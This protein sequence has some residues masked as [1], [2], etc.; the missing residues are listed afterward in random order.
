MVKKNRALALA[1]ALAGCSSSKFTG[2]SPS[3][4]P[5]IKNQLL[6]LVGFTGSVVKREKRFSGYSKTAERI[7]LI[8][9][10]TESE[11][12]GRQLA[13]SYDFTA[14]L[15]DYSGIAMLQGQ[16]F[17]L[18]TQDSE[19]DF[20]PFPFQIGYATRASDAATYGAVSLDGTSVHVE[21][22]AGGSR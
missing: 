18:V 19:R 9:P 14:P 3:T 20:E 15:P 5:F 8:N 11:V 7:S 22:P 6:T 2:D 17:S 16:N 12:W 21:V 1:L 4:T 10:E 13:G